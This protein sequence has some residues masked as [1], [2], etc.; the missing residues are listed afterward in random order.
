MRLKLTI[1]YDGTAYSGWQTQ[2]S[3]SAPTI[4]GAVETAL[5][6]LTRSRIRL[7]GAGR[8]DA[9]VHAVGQTAHCDV[10]DGWNCWARRL[11]AVLP[12]DIRVLAAEPAEPDFHAR[13]QALSKTYIYRFWQERSCILPH[14][15]GYVW[16]CGPLDLEVIRPGIENFL[17]KHDFASFQNTGSVVCSTEREILAIDIQPEISGFFVPDCPPV[18]ALTITATGFLKQM[19]RNIAGFIVAVSRKKA[20]WQDLEAIFSARKRTALKSPTAPAAG[21][22]LARVDYGRRQ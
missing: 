22:C 6:E 9:G 15:R 8:T 17:G 1:A 2:A 19:A 10:P 20:A 13:F 21:L 16:G 3:L 5:F 7:H 11:N 14:M 4:Q 12:R 18:L